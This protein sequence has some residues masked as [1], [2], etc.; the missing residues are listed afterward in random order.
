MWGAVRYYWIATK[1]YRLRPWRSPYVRWRLE[2]FF[3]GEA[4][5]KDGGAGDAGTFFRLLWRERRRLV[6]MLRWSEER[7]AE[8]RSRSS[9][10]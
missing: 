8:Q 4:R 2:T 6:R 1:G 5:L 3:G 10:L 9:H 7:R